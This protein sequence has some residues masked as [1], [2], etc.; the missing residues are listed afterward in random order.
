M[1]EFE[2]TKR[3]VERTQEYDRYWSFVTGGS[4]LR[5]RPCSQCGHSVKMLHP[6][7]S[8]ESLRSRINRLLRAQAAHTC[9]GIST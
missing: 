6:L 8:R 3:L 7:T 9:K 4:E 2:T 1:T 5:S